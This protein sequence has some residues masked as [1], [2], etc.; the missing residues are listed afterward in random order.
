LRILKLDRFYSYWIQLDILCSW[1]S[2]H[3]LFQ[4]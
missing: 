3:C 4:Q 2:L 1:W